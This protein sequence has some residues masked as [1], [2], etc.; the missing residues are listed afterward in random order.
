V[1][2]EIRP[3]S[4]LAGYRLV[5][6][7]GRGGMSTVFVAEDLHLG[8]AVA[9]KVLSSDLAENPEFRDRFVRESRLAASLD[10]PNIVPVYSAGE[11]EGVLYIAMRYVEGTDLKTL[12]R[13]EGD[14]GLDR[15]VE[16][17]G[18]VA[19]AL[20]AAHEAGLV[21]RDVKPGNILLAHKKGSPHAY[22]AD[23]GLTKQTASTTGFT[24][25]GQFLG[26][27]DYAAPEQIQGTALDGRTDQYSLGCVAYQCLTGE[28]P[29]P[30]EYEM[31]TLW[32][33]VQDPPPRVSEHRRELPPALDEVIA[34]AMAKDPNNRFSTT[35][36]FVAQ[37][38]TARG[39]PSDLSPAGPL[40]ASTYRHTLPRT[41]EPLVSE[42]HETRKV[43]TVLFT[44]V[45]GS[46]ALGE[47]LD[48]E[49]LRNAMGHYFHAM[50][51]V[52]ERHGGK[53]EKFIG[54]AIMAVFGIPELHEDDALRAVRAADEMR[55][56]LAELN[57]DLQRDWGVT[58]ATRTGVNTG[59]VVAG[60]PSTGRTLVTGDAVNVAARL[61]QTAA[62]G[63]I[64]LGELTHRL[65]RDGV[66]VETV[67]P[68]RAKGKTDP[69]EAVRLLE[70]I[71]GA[72]AH[73]RRLDSP[74]VGRDR[75]LRLLTE[76]LDHA[77]SERTCH[78]FT[79]LGPAGVGKSRLVLEFLHSVSSTTVLS[80]RCLSY[81]EGITFFPLAEV[82][83]KAA[84]ITDEDSP[85]QARAKI[86]QTLPK[87][88]QAHLIASAVAE[89]IGL[90]QRPVSSEDAFWAAR[91]F[92]EGLAQAGPLIVVFDDVH[93]AEPAFLDL[94]EH[95]ADWSRDVP[96][97]LL[98]MARP[99]LLD[100]RPG[101]GGGKLNATSILLGPLGSEEAE[102]LID[103]LLGAEGFP[104][105]A[106][107]RILEAAEGN[108]LFVEEMLGMLVDDSLLTRE[109]GRWVISEEVKDITIPPTIH[110]L[111][112]ARLDRLD[113]GDRAVAERAS[114]EGQVFHRGAVVR[115]SPDRDRQQVGTRLQSLA[116]KELI[117]PGG[118]TFAGEDAFRFRHLLIRDAAY[119]GMLKETRGKLHLL[120]ADWLSERVGERLP[121]YEDILGYHLEQAYRYRADLGPI[122]EEARQLAQRAA[123]T[124]VSA[125]QRAADRDDHRAAEGL[126]LRAIELTPMESPERRRLR[127]EL[128]DELRWAGAFRE[129]EELANEVIV[130]ARQALDRRIEAQATALRAW[131]LPSL[132]KSFTLQTALSQATEAMKTLEGL[133]DVEGVFRASRTVADLMGD[134]GRVDESL[135]LTRAQVEQAARVG[136]VREVR[137]IARSHSLN[138]AYGSTPAGKAI[139]EVEL[140]VGLV[141]DSPAAT[142][143]VGPALASLYA[144]VGRF[145]D[146]REAA[147]RNDALVRELG[148]P[149]GL[150]HA[151]LWIFPMHMLAGE[152]DAAERK[153]REAL[154]ILESFG[155]K[156]FTSSV[157]VLLAE[158][159]LAQGRH[160]EAEAFA[161][162]GRTLASSDDVFPQF[163]WRAV[164][165][166][167][168]A[169]RGSFAEAERLAREAV[170][171]GDGTSFIN[172]RGDLWRRLGEVLRLAGNEKEAADAM[173]RA[174]DLY[175]RKGNEVMA[176][177]T[178]RE[179][180]ELGTP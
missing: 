131:L 175:E 65:V 136:A 62:P 91:T 115:L 20:D 126:L 102:E 78:L 22:L 96:I 32:A 123:A 26:T 64:L 169:T 149:F 92:L 105:E 113:A 27:L 142:A 53:V 111:L 59:T 152:F 71:P 51:T 147:D 52:L 99:E 133:G 151:P 47:Q 21:H 77:V 167:V 40:G 18:Q 141:A 82:V 94:V 173:R 135:E 23:F 69:V 107:T 43:V 31:A 120:F 44:D 93:W 104:A 103:K 117:R 154:A 148:S 83:R 158:S 34:R 109:D 90:H 176:E 11:E 67:G 95:V 97:L 36:E 19:G 153:L 180:A 170:K 12:I 129:A 66:R 54:D 174:L 3:G 81:G 124:L 9:L 134:L 63:E 29:F 106:R 163:Q 14:L 33:H 162:R 41:A 8:R 110:L 5:S 157:V 80:G 179:L 39:A 35:G 42:A 168:H 24:S 6:L 2:A 87:N 61:E 172:I 121:E 164:V 130:E 138:L 45:A 178:R 118:A 165:A 7:L 57:Q 85:D 10:H 70:V 100:L 56:A 177:R 13:D 25:S 58:I 161:E 114:V 143:Q 122:D 139:E 127:H 75:E 38:G 79:L 17:L 88:E 86:G 15:T 159:L 49:S 98:C 137:A 50:K 4:D 1:T 55:R 156:G 73:A 76:A 48:P 28:V 155:D 150:V 140:L 37:L 116:R 146:A 128:A 60:D 171:L 89:L 112:A 145:D 16:I 72:E 125:A 132:D 101:W 68:R 74:M 46:T 160:D 108:P 84:G 119:E 30:R 144:M 166:K